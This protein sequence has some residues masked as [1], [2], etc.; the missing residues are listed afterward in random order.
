MDSVP[1]EDTV[2][3]PT[4]PP[5]HAA[6]STSCGACFP[7]PGRAKETQLTAPGT[8]TKSCHKWAPKSCH[9]QPTSQDPA[10]AKASLDSRGLM[11]TLSRS[12]GMN[13]AGLDSV[14]AQGRVLRVA[15][16]QFITWVRCNGPCQQCL[17]WHCS[18]HTSTLFWGLMQC[19]FPLPPLIF[20][21]LL[22]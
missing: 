9:L 12:A 3:F 17:P 19:P 14:G 7:E 4:G 13:Q 22:T 20:C 15:R 21:L 10:P 16:S 6:A 18:G 1:A 2:W 11:L 8:G 5:Y